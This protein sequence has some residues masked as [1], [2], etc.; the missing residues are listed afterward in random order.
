MTR[1]DTPPA[2]PR[3]RRPEREQKPPRTWRRRL[4]IVVG[5]LVVLGVLTFIIAYGVANLVLGINSSSGA[6]NTATDFLV[7]LESQNYDQAYKDLDA[8]IT[9]SVQPPQFKQMTAADDLCYGKV[10]GFTEVSGSAT[11]SNNGNTQ[12]YTYSMTRSKL[13]KPFQL[14][15]TIQKDSDGTWDI[16]NY[17]NDLGPNPPSSTCK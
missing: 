17:G 6:G 11:T 10:T 15:L 16:T 5:V 9:V 14:T 8:T 2:T 4:L 12:S 3:V 13:S 7:N 1:L